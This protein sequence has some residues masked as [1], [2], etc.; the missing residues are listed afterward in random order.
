MFGTAI[1]IPGADIANAKVQLG[2][3]QVGYTGADGYYAFS[4]LQAG[5][6]S[7]TAMADGFS[8]E[9]AEAIVIPGEVAWK[10]MALNPLPEVEE[11]AE[12]PEP[13]EEVVEEIPEEEPE[14]TEE[15]R[16]PVESEDEEVEEAPVVEQAPEEELSFG[17]SADEDE[18]GSGGLAY[19]PSLGAPL[20]EVT[21][22]DSGGEGCQHSSGGTGLI[23]LLGA[24]LLLAVRQGAIAR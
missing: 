13:T 10:S 24:L 21:S 4:D 6:V 3:G 7:V 8:P 12:E 17:V 14:I 23:W 16:Q 5:A 1:F 19:S 9:T 18:A 20:Q 11:P 15:P 22:A 2:N